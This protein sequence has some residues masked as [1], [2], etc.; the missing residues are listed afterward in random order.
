MFNSIKNFI[1]N[2]YNAHYFF[3]KGFVNGFFIGLG[4]V[5]LAVFVLFA[6]DAHLCAQERA[7]LHEQQC[8][9]AVNCR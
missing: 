3:F 2:F 1:K 6:I 4:G 9:F 5:I 8:L 7:D